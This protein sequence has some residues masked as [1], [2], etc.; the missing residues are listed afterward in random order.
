ML[1]ASQKWQEECKKGKQLSLIGCFLGDKKK[2]GA[3]LVR[4]AFQ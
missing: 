3:I 1:V 2:V 4:N